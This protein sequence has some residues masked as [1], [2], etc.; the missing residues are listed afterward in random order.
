M[1]PATSGR[2]GQAG[3]EAE[4]VRER[5][6]LLGPLVMLAIGAGT[7][8]VGSRVEVSTERAHWHGVEGPKC[9][10]RGVLGDRACPGCGLTRATALVL[11]G[12][13]REAWEIHEGGFVVVL[14]CGAS[15]PFQVDIIRR[16]GRAPGHRRWGRIGRLSL[17]AGVLGPWLWH[18]LGG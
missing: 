9:L 15:I 8:A 6:A 14:L 17:L 1:D 16:R 5:R 3:G 13:F 12:R 11:Q 18:A 2:S 4:P 10:V 7:L